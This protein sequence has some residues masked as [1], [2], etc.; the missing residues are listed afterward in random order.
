MSLQSTEEVPWFPTS[1]EDLNHIGNTLSEGEDFDMVDH[2]SFNDSEYKE[3]RAFLTDVS[4]N[5]KVTD[6]EIPRIDYLP[7]EKATWQTVF[8]GLTELYPE[9]AC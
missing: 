9:M 3:R 6:P 2:P 8:E 5:Y 1:F 4:L 7:N